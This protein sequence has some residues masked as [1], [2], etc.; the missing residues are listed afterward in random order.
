MKL[1]KL[2]R[3]SAPRTIGAFFLLM[4][5]ALVGTSAFGLPVAPLPNYT[6]LFFNNVEVL[7]DKDQNGEVSV[8]DT[9]YG[10]FEVQNIKNSP[11]ITGQTGK[12]IWTPGGG[13]AEITGYFASDVVATLPPGTIPGTTDYVIVLGDPAVDPNGILGPGEAMRIYEDTNIDFDS[14]TI[15]SGL[16]TATDGTLWA[17]FGIGNPAQGPGNSAY[18]YTLAPL[19]P[20]GSGD[21]GESFAGLNAVIPPTG[22]NFIG[23][24]DPN[25]DYSSGAGVPGGLTVDL[26]F[27]SEIFALTSN[28]SLGDDDD[29][30]DFGSND[31]AVFQAIPEPA[32]M[33]LVGSGL[34]G[35]AG[36]GRRKF[37]KK[38]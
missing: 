21:V 9:F 20:P 10:I 38:A 4:A 14:T 8:G 5:V 17:S 23:I 19:V 32:T 37:F 22:L 11:D 34:I 35:L 25:E 16:A 13:P 2:I 7:L 1:K 15:S 30:W 3:L 33:L 27:N 29:L 31:P 6:G 36:L 24:N 12:N 28:A 18:W 26:Y